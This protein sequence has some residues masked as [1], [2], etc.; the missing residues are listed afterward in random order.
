M[1]GVRQEQLYQCVKELHE[2]GYAVFG[3]CNILGLNR[4]SY[5]KW[6]KRAKSRTQAENELLLHDIGVIYAER[7]LRISPHCG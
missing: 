4:S 3:I 5:Y 6:T 7:H 2:T 1:S